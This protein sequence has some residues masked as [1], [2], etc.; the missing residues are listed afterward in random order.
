[1]SCAWAFFQTLSI[2]PKLVTFTFSYP[3]TLIKWLHSCLE[4]KP[5]YR[6]YITSISHHHIPNHPFSALLFQCG[7]CPL[8]SKAIPPPRLRFFSEIMHSR[9]NPSPSAPPLLFFCLSTSLSFSIPSPLSYSIGLCALSLNINNQRKKILPN[10]IASPSI[11]FPSF[12]PWLIF[13]FGFNFFLPTLDSKS[14]SWVHCPAWHC[15]SCQDY[16]CHPRYYTNT[17]QKSF[18]LKTLTG[19][20]HHFATLFLSHLLAILFHEPLNTGS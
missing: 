7:D 4:N 3:L 20:H 2:I 1:M 6:N 17:M 14:G 19:H 10:F 8:P 18:F 5:S 13:L 15:C 16:H 11:L 12:L 9:I